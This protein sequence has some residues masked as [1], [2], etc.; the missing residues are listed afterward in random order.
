MFR[1]YRVILRKLVV[2]TLPSYEL[3]EDDTAVS[4]HLEEYD[5]S[6]IIC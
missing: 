2:S 5:N 4:K 1:H 3:P 6:S